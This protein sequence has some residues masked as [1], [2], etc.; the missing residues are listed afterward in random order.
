MNR[1][2]TWTFEPA[3]AAGEAVSGGDILGYVHFSDSNRGYPGSGMI[4]FKAYDHAL[5]DVNY[6]GYIVAEYQPYPTAM[7]SAVRGLEYMR[8]MERAAEIERLTFKE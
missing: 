1:E 6:Q 3:A 8:L 5:M 2:K 7:E 4:D